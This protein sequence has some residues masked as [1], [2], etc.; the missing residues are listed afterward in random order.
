L[1][2]PFVSTAQSAQ[3]W[4]HQEKMRMKHDVITLNEERSVTLTALIQEVGGEFRGIS[5]RPAV[6]VIPGGGYLFCSDREAEAVAFSY[7]KAG[8]HA[9]VL[10][11]SVGE[12]SKWPQPLEDY[13]AAMEYIR[14]HSDQWHVMADKIAVIGFSAG[15]HL[16]GSLAILHNDPRVLSALGISEGENRPDAVIMSYPVVSALL[17]THKPS[18]EHLTGGIP[19]DEIPYDLK[20]KLSLETQVNRSSAPLF[21]WHA[22]RD[23]LVPTNG[24][25]ALAQRYIDEKINVMLKIY[26][27]GTH[28]LALANRLTAE[29]SPTLIHSIAEKWIDEADEWLQAFFE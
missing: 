26:P 29:G 8:F 17:P 25:L 3:N 5:Q 16:A 18:F 2:R 7:L 14:S 6:L 22:A 1:S 13:E 9:F 19:F 11:Y 4:L 27:K 28:G 10:R 15:G 23:G 20:Q 21:I 24:S 12:H